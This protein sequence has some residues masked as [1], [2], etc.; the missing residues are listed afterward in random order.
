MEKISQII[1]LFILISFNSCIIVIP[2]KTYVEKEPEVFK[3]IDI[4]NYWGKNIIYSE[5]LI[6]TP[7]QKISIIINSQNFGTHLFKNMCDLPNS[8]FERNESSSFKYYSNIT[9]LQINNASVINETIY[10]YDSLKLEKRIPLN[11]YR[12]IYSDNEESI[13][14]YQNN[15][16]IDLGLLLRWDNYQDVPTNLISQLKS[17][18]KIIETF[19][20][21]FKY[22]SESEGVIVIGQE[23]HL[24]DPENYFE[25]QYRIYGANGGEGQYDW[26][27]FPDASY[28]SYKKEINGK[29]EIINEP[30]RI[31]R[32]LQIKFDLGL[33]I[34][35]NEFRSMIK[36]LFFDN[37]ITEEKCFE[38]KIKKDNYGE[39]YIYYCDKKLTEEFIKNEF[40][41]IY[42][43]VKHFNK[44]FELTYKDLFREKDGKLYF[45]M[46]FDSSNI[47]PYI[48][49]GS[50]FLKKY[51]FTFNQDSKMIGYYNENLPGGKTKINNNNTIKYILFIVV[52]I[53]IIIFGILGFFVGKFVYDTIRKK[54][55]NEIDDNYDYNPQQDN[56]DEDKKNGL[57][58]NE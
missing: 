41:N 23:P 39:I 13:Y 15:T 2:F 30:I 50:I 5:T 31:M 27:L 20:I 38:E 33:I 26:F 35:T 8:N 29:I 11:F 54:R 46:Y 47:G 12:I 7:P 45:L 57:I 43:D 32:A 18:Y 40:P 19:D 24:Y 55:I 22:N 44:T 10:F 3:P 6:G 4:I 17:K 28:I 58:L 1:L 14:E 52:P 48:T 36:K 51:F 9:Y 25:M 34:G 21:S 42:F 16:C 49:V 53:L 56:N 37:L